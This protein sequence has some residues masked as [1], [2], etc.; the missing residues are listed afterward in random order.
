[1]ADL[2]TLVDRLADHVQDATQG[3]RADRNRNR[4]AGI[5]DG[6]TADETVGGVHRDGAH[7]TLTQMLGDFENQRLAVVLGVQGVQNRGQLGFELDVDDRARDLGNLADSVAR[8]GNSSHV[9]SLPRNRYSVS[10]A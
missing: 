9:G 4:A 8:L 6:L 5:V 10:D 3:G 7:G 2:A 1:M